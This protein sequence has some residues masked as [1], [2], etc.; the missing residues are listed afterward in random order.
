MKIGTFVFHL[1]ITKVKEEILIED[2][3]IFTINGMSVNMNPVGY[4]IESYKRVMPPSA[5]AGMVSWEGVSHNGR[6]FFY[7]DSIT[8][9][10]YN[11]IPNDIKEMYVNKGDVIVFELSLLNNNTPIQV[12][13]TCSLR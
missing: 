1:D 6:N 11:S 8:R 4:I 5:K 9:P 7:P 13:V 12:T 2:Q 10:N 3:G